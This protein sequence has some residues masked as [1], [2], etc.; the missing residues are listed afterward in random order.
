MLLCR[1]NILCNEKEAAIG[2]ASSTLSIVMARASL[3]SELA[4]RSGAQRS[5][6]QRRSPW[7][8][9]YAAPRLSNEP[10]CIIE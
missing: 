5:R 8:L 6:L 7:Q 9:V 3:A 1:I 2:L 4:S 10:E